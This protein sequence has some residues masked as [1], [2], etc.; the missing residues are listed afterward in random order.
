M[1]SLSSARASFDMARAILWICPTHHMIGR[2]P[3][4][5]DVN[6][7]GMARAVAG[8]GVR[9]Y[10]FHVE[11][12]PEGARSGEGRRTVRPALRLHAVQ[13][14]GPLHAHSTRTHAHAHAH[15]FSKA[16][17]GHEGERGNRT[18]SYP[19][20]PSDGTAG[21]VLPICAYSWSSV[22]ERCS[23]PSGGRERERETG[24]VS[25]VSH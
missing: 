5:L 8:R 24:R 1:R 6:E 23:A 10:Q 25:G 12:S 4:T 9:Y 19:M 15:A 7:R 16:S 18:H 20:M 2:T 13:A 21:A 14:L 11:S 3:H 22:F 17:H